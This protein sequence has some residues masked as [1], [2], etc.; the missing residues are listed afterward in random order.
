MAL[1]AAIACLCF[2]VS[3][4]EAPSYPGLPSNAYSLDMNRACGPICLAFLDAYYGAN[5]GC[6]AIAPMCPPGSEGTSL[7]QLQ[8]AAGQLGY[9]TLAF[10]STASL[11]PRLKY[12][13]ILHLR[14]TKGRD[15]FI[16]LTKWNITLGKGVV[17]SPPNNISLMSLDS[18][19]ERFSGCGL[20]VAQSSELTVK[21][22]VRSSDHRSLRTYFVILAIAFFGVCLVRKAARRWPRRSSSTVA[23]AL[24]VSVV[25][26]MSSCRGGG[27]RSEGRQVDKGEVLQ[28]TEVR[29]T[30]V[31][32][33]NGHNA[34]RV[35]DIKKSCTCQIIDLDMKR[36]VAVGENLTARVRLST[37][38]FDGPLK[39]QFVLRTDSD[40]PDL[41]TIVLSLNVNVVAKIKILPSQLNYGNIGPREDATKQVRV[42]SSVP[43]L[44]ETFRNVESDNLFLTIKLNE[45]RPGTLLFD[46]VLEKGAP[47]GDI[48]GKIVFYFNSHEFPQIEAVVTGRKVGAIELVP[49]RLYV[50]ASDNVA[51]N[52]SNILL[53]ST[54]NKPFRVVGLE[55]SRGVVA[56]LDKSNGDTERSVHMLKVRVF[57]TQ[58]SDENVTFITIRTTRRDHPILKIPIIR[59]AR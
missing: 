28:G 56:T 30:F 15:H 50:T 49:S 46:A 43:G 16:V 5:R 34:F 18:L 48:F 37:S 42:E 6:A 19:S 11:L 45:K 9:G 23:V 3:A 10:K 41:R 7:E 36:P 22:A 35:T 58:L 59:N 32:R 24:L 14:N 27:R 38:G 51:P 57:P 52:E 1:L 13:A 26:G 54:D 39:K 12:P 53:R 20:I 33:N 40:T 2:P 47:R 31:I 8:T 29:H 44:L 17:F 21:T 4:G 55:S 25:F